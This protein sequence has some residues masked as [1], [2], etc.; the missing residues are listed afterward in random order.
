M[1]VT[2]QAPSQFPFL[3]ILSLAEEK[4]KDLYIASYPF[5]PLKII[6]PERYTTESNR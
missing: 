5:G 4:K 6:Q 2:N 1:T 3:V